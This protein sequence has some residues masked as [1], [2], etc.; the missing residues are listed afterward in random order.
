MLEDAVD[1]NYSDAFEVLAR[2]YEDGVLV[3]KNLQ[4]AYVLYDLEGRVPTHPE[5][6]NIARQ[7]TNEQLKAARRASW[8]WQETH[9]S[10]RPGYPIKASIEVHTADD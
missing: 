9:N 7:L 6:E 2:L 3:P 4:R 5:K 1:K 8:H 10:Y